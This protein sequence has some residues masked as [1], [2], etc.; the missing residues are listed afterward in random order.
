M[1][2]IEPK[3]GFELTT[4]RSRPELECRVGHLTNRATQVPPRLIF[5]P[6]NSYAVHPKSCG[7]KLG[8]VPYRNF[9][10]FIH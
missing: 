2:S 1:P 10:K 9:R 3:V 4:L 7:K 8:E 5:D 6:S